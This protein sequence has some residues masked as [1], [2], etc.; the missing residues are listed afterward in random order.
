[1]R[2][3]TQRR[4]LRVCLMVFYKIFQSWAII[5]FSK[6]KVG[7]LGELRV[8]FTSERLWLQP[9]KVSYGNIGILNEVEYCESLLAQSEIFNY[10]H[11]FKI[12]SL[13]LNHLKFQLKADYQSYAINVVHPDTFINKK[14]SVTLHWLNLMFWW[15]QY[16]TPPQL[17]M[18]NYYNN[19]TLKSMHY[20]DT[21]WN[22]Q[23]IIFLLLRNK[24]HS[25]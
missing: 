4:S 11:F 10:H 3:V 23:A 15:Y 18:L 12:I 7:I 13:Q 1:M 2:K 20:T 22:F 14:I 5:F 21:T 16:T 24:L 25:L 8:S 9:F 19:N 6:S 17:Q